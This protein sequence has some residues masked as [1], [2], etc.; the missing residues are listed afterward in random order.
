LWSCGE[1]ISAIFTGYSRLS[2]QV[3]SKIV[4]HWLCVVMMNYNWFSTG[5]LRI[6]ILL[7]E[8]KTLGKTLLHLQ[9]A[10]SNIE[11]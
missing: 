7:S 5:P 4:H 1:V 3:G 11:K 9:N 10:D 6:T 8:S 2:T